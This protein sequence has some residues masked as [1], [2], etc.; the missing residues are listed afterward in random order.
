VEAGWVSWGDWLGTS[1]VS[2]RR[3]KFWSFVKARAF[4]R[5]LGLESETDWRE[6]RKSGKKPDYIPSNPNRTYA[7]S[8]WTGMGDWLGTGRVAVPRWQ[9]SEVRTVV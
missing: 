4:V 6:Y 1:R 3:R 7:D 2:N 5:N 8:G 9:K